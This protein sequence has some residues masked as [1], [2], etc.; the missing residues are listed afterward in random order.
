MRCVSGAFL[1]AFCFISLLP[2]DVLASDAAELLTPS[3]RWVRGDVAAAD[4]VVS[5]GDTSVPVDE[6]LALRFGGRAA[7]KTMEQSAVFGDGQ[8]LS[9]RVESVQGIKITFASAVLGTVTLRTTSV[10]TLIMQPHKIS[11]VHTLTS[12]GAGALLVNGDLVA[13]RISFVNASKVGVYSGRKIVQIP[14]DRVKL[15]RFRAAF[16]RTINPE[17]MRSTQHVRLLTGD[18]LSG[19]LKTIDDENAVLMTGVA[20]KVTIPRKRIYEIWTEGGPVI[21]LSLL[22]PSDVKQIPQ[23]DEHFPHKIDKSQAGTALS[24]GGRRYERGIGCHSKCEL[25]FELG[26]AWKAFVTDIG[27]DDHVGR[28]GEVVFRV[29]V[30]GETKYESSP[31]RGAEQARTVRVDL[32]GAKQ[33]T[34]VVDF[35]PDGSGSGDQANWARALLI[36]APKK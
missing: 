21:P 3:G 14:R 18:L 27:I 30:D 7:W 8:L 23:F 20:G 25:Q 5:I 9:G 32:T 16:R 17:T 22:K 11:D 26:G 12:G 13:G 24:I 28:R 1:A 15:V 4:G 35:G 6:L 2:F 31:V 36:R 29:L 10:Q 33:M 34:L 19:K